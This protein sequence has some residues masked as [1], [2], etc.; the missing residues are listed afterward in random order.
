MAGRLAQRTAPEVVVARVVLRGEAISKEHA[1][2]PRLEEGEVVHL[3]AGIAGVAA[4]QR[5]RLARRTGD[6][7]LHLVHD[8]RR[9]RTE[10]EVLRKQ[11]V[12]RSVGRQILLRRAEGHGR[13]HLQ[14]AVGGTIDAEGDLAAAADGLQHRR[15]TRP[16][17][18]APL[19][20]QRHREAGQLA[21]AHHHRRPGDPAR[22]QR[23]GLHRCPRPSHRDAAQREP[24]R[25]EGGRIDRNRPA[26]QPQL[27]GRRGTGTHHLDRHV[28]QV[29]LLERIAVPIH[30]P[31]TGIERLALLAAHRRVAARIRRTGVSRSG[32]HRGVGAAVRRGVG[33][34]VSGR[35]GLRIGHRRVAAIGRGIHGG[36]GVRV[37]V[38]RVVQPRPVRVLVGIGRHIGSLAVAQVCRRAG[39]Q[40]RQQG[41]D[42]SMQ[43]HGEG[44]FR[45]AAA[46]PR[47][48]R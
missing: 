44:S 35:I 1:A 48:V 39:Q 45:R 25:R 37:T 40:Q 14:R 46:Q 11:V 3:P 29:A 33:G 32:I 18:L 6:A 5:H 13:R 30:Q 36:V 43:R 10:D 4:R 24:G 8:G 47:T 7:E 20:V 22:H 9:L 17:Q 34:G 26:L 23:I 41:G 16:R 2:R 31:H 21:R 42:E 19:A 28:E 15:S 38:G 27:T 12:S